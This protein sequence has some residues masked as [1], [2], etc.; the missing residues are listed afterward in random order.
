MD[1]KRLNDAAV[2]LHR[3]CTKQPNDDIDYGLFGD[4]AI[5]VQGRTRVPGH[6]TTYKGYL[7]CLARATKHRVI[8]ALDDQEGFKF[9]M[10]IINLREDFCEF[11]WSD[12]PNRQDE[13]ILRVFCDPIFGWPVQADMT[14]GRSIVSG[15]RVSGEVK[16]VDP[17][18]LLKGRIR[19][20]AMGFILEHGADIYLI[21]TEF[22]SYVRPNAGA[23]NLAYVGLALNNHAYL[24]PLFADLNLDIAEAKRRAQ[25]RGPNSIRDEPRDVWLNLL[26]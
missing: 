24:E 18:H 23:L 4:Y 10:S 11:S 12:S 1:A 6:S 16:F 9:H 2:C 26:F 5:A 3:A 20:A 7:E 13:V 19:D 17:I 25:A 15:Y 8:N 21:A 22:D 14:I